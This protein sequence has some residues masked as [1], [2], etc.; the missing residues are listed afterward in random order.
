V[1]LDGSTPALA[2]VY[3]ALCTG[4]SEC[5]VTLANGQIGTSGLVIQREQVLSLSQGGS[6]TKTDVGMGVATTVLFGL[7]GLIGFAAKKPRLHLLDQLRPH[8]AIHSSGHSSR[9]AYC[10][11]GAVAELGAV[12]LDYFLEIGST[13]AN[14][15]SYL[16]YWVELLKESPRA[17]LQVIGDARRAADLICPELMDG[18]SLQ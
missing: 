8:E 10:P 12:L 17:L 5:T 11:R 2:G 9:R 3:E 6:G 16:G 13:I 1:A 15:A 18:A 4:A 14:H 7:P